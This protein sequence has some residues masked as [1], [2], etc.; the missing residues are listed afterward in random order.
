M[1]FLFKKGLISEPFL[2]RQAKAT[3]RFLL[4][5][6]GGCFARGKGGQEK[7]RGGKAFF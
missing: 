3:F 5:K 4:A 2:K 1:L 7:A 6:Q